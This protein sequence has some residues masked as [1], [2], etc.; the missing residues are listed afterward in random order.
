MSKLTAR[1]PQI[2]ISSLSIFVFEVHSAGFQI[3][4]QTVA[5]LGRAFAGGGV[6]GDDASDMF[7]NPAGMLLNGGRQ[8]QAGLTFLS[9]GSHFSNQ[10]SSQRLLTPTGPLT[11]PSVGPDDD[12]GEDAVVPNFFYTLPTQPNGLKF[13]IGVTAPFGLKTDY[14]GGWVGRFHALESELKTIDINPAVAYRV[15]DR[16]VIGAGLSAQYADATLSRAVFTGPGRPAGFA[17]VQGDD[18]G[19]GYNLGLMIEIDDRSRVGISWRSK[20]TQ[21]VEGSRTLSGTGTARD[22]RVGAKAEVDLPDTLYIEGYKR[23]NRWAVLAGLRWSNWSRFQ[24]LRIE[25]DDGSP[26]DVT[27]EDWED[28]VT[29]SIGFIYHHGNSPWTFRGGYALDETPVPN[30]ERRTPRIPDG[31]RDWLTFGFSYRPPKRQNISIDAGYAHLFID[32][33]RINNTINLVPTAPGAFTDT[34]VGQYD[35]DVD[36]LGVQVQILFE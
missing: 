2:L 23:I 35:G 4:E 15:N 14:G 5:G 27:A 31:D 25:F 18:W 17:K 7:Y 19:Y 36:L 22:G 10:G 16:L 6:S 21:K 34:L 3:S 28:T 29:L 20:I 1:I 33:T 32:D 13:G 12:G 11:V 30:A 24:E 26:D 8:F 9:I